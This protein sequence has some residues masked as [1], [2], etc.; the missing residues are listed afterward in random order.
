MSKPNFNFEKYLL[1][2]RLI[3]SPTDKIREFWEGED[4]DFDEITRQNGVIDRII[5]IITEYR[6]KSSNEQFIKEYKD[7][8][9]DVVLTASEVNYLISVLVREYIEH[10]YHGGLI[11]ISDLAEYCGVL[12]GELYRILVQM[13]SENELKIITR[14]FCPEFHWI[15]PNVNDH[16]SYCEECDFKYPN[17][18]LEV[19]VYIQPLKTEITR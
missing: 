3:R 18:Q 15:K 7:F 6:I 10:K 5:T 16:Q 9:R 17:E 4:V 1:I 13:Q 19:A 14:Y 11:G 2:R 8:L 12:E